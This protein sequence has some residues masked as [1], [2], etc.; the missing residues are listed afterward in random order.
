[1]ISK[2]SKAQNLPVLPN[3]HWISSKIKRVPVSSHLLRTALKYSLQA[4]LIPASPCIVSM[5]TPA[6]RSSIFSKSE[7]LEAEPPGQCVTG[8][9]PCNERSKI[10][11]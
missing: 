9:E 8:R 4:T 1:M 7:K 3:P 11:A 2:C 6:V 10:V 5:M